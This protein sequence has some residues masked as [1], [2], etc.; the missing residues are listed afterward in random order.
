[1][2]V[3]LQGQHV[4]ARGRVLSRSH[5]GLCSGRAGS[6]S[7][8]SEMGFLR[9]L[10]LVLC[11]GAAAAMYGD[12][13]SDDTNARKHAKPKRPTLSM[14]LA[15]RPAVVPSP[16]PMLPL[17]ASSSAEPAMPFWTQQGSSSPSS[18]SCGPA[19][20]DPRSASCGP[21][22]SEP[23]SCG[24]AAS[25]P[26]SASCGPAAKPTSASCGPASKPTSAS[27]GP[28]SASCGPASASSSLAS[29]VAE[30]GSDSVSE[31]SSLDE[32]D[33]AFVGLKRI[34]W[35][36]ALGAPESQMDS[37]PFYGS[38]RC[39]Q[40]HWQMPIRYM[41]DSM[42]K[43][44]WRSV[45]WQGKYV[46]ADDEVTWRSG[47]WSRWSWHWAYWPKDGGRVCWHREFES[48]PS[49]PPTSP[50]YLEDRWHW[51]EPQDDE[52]WTWDPQE[53]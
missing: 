13:S 37:P 40:W 42:K 31:R 30:W 51:E 17:P 7:L 28:A 33:Y 9:F 3:L 1:M 11:V 27:C 45:W 47:G 16:L 20:S 10:A 39:H 8:W 14:F 5:F 53:D 35:R 24:P 52:D 46:M 4:C 43:R 22:A 23:A 6:F 15:K 49:T 32:N 48:P 21:G 36:D 18:S 41:D 29:D 26:A 50:E 25:E 19:V 44:G 34:G 12:G 2:I 38:S